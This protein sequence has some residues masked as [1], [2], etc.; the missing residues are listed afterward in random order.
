MQIARGAARRLREIRPRTIVLSAWLFGIVYA[1]PGF[2]NWDAGW[3]LSQAR[4]N[5]YDDWH[6]PLMAWYW[7]QIERF[8]HGPFGML[9]LQTALF[10]WGLYAAF[11]RR[12]RPRTAAVLAAIVFVAPPVLAPMGVTWKDAQSAA[13]MLAGVMLALRPEWWK[14]ALGVGMLFLS[15]GVKYNAP[16][17]LLPLALVIAREWGVR[18]KLVAAIAALAATAAISKCAYDTN[19]R[20]RDG[21]SLVWYRT[22]A[23]HDI[24]GAICNEGPMSDA[25][26]LDLTAGIPLHP[27][28]PLQHNICLGYTSRVAYLSLSF[29]E[30]WVFHNMPDDDERAARGAAWWRVVTEHTGAWLAHRWAIMRNVLGLVDDDPW[31]PVCLDYLADRGAEHQLGHDATP[32]RLGRWIATKWMLRWTKTLLFRPWAYVVVGLVL[33]GYAVRRR[34]LWIGALVAS[35]VAM[36]ASLFLASP[37]SDFRYSHWMITCV[38]IAALTVFGE[39]YRDG[40]ARLAETET[41]RT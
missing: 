16:V 28:P 5:M 3:Q 18:R 20:I 29:G 39:R 22:I 12:F 37:G 23:A 14:R 38:C 15:V 31:E 9:V 4:A 41:S 19:L 17:A 25:E 33:F 27:G 6:P 34:D 26:I 8:I 32:S 13:W 10:A 35:G 7:R 2:M 1:Y 24:A 36:E 11:G 30:H 40:S 21:R